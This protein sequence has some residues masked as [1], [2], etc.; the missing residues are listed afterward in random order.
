MTSDS[1]DIRRDTLFSLLPGNPPVGVDPIFPPSQTVRT[2]G[3]IKEV[4]RS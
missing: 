4:S 2:Y 3:S 1:A